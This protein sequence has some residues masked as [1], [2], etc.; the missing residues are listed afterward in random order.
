[1]DYSSAIQKLIEEFNKFPGI[2]S[3]TSE[4]FVFYLLTLNNQELENLGQYIRELKNKI[5]TCS[6]CL[7]FSETDPCDLCADKKRDH[8]IICVVATP[9]DLRAIEKTRQFQGIYHVLGG[10]INPSQGVTPEKLNIHQL[11]QRIKNNKIKE[12][13]TAFNPDMEGE[14]TLLYLKKILSPFKIKITRLARGLP[15]GSDLDYA[16]EITLADALKDRREV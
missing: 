16:D 7:N 12:I 8:Q 9:Q 15:V 11:I 5:T 3:K 14:T 6:I 4:R 10:T 1:M 13:I 2:G